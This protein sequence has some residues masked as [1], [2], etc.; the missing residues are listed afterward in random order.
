MSQQAMHLKRD[1]FVILFKVKTSWYLSQLVV[2]C[3]TDILGVKMSA[4]LMSYID[5]ANLFED[6]R[7]TLQY[8]L[9]VKYRPHFETRFQ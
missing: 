6:D 5:K 3:T 8:F 1:K 9:S 4:I 2:N 7:M